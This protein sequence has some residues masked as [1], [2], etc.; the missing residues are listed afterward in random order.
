MMKVRRIIGMGA[1]AL[2]ASCQPPSSGDVPPQVEHLV[3]DATRDAGLPFSDAVR[4]GHMIYVSGQVGTVPGTSDLVPGGIGPETRQ[5]LDN[6]RTILERHGSSME[7]VVKC[8]V[9]LADIRE[10]GEMNEVYVTFFREPLPARS[11]L[12]ANGLALGAHVEIEC[13]ATVGRSS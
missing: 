10:W 9:M 8:T 1:L 12:G 11:A 5:A 7:R 2:L 13:W 4:V 3:S 6:I